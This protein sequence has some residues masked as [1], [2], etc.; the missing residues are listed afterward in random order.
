MASGDSDTGAALRPLQG[1]ARSSTSWLSM[2]YTGEHLT[3]ELPARG[4]RAAPRRG[5][6]VDTLGYE[7]V[8]QDRV[9]LAET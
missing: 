4:V 6:P 1:S 5:L 3:R 9:C 2:M 8:D 7:S